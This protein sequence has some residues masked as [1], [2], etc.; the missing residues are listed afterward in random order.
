MQGIWENGKIRLCN[1]KSKKMYISRENKVF[2]PKNKVLFNYEKN[3][4]VYIKNKEMYI[5]LSKK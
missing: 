2:P 5:F 1:M 3:K 4:E